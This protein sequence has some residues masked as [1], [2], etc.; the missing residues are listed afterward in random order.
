ML[1]FNQHKDLL[2]LMID[3]AEGEGGKEE[4]LTDEE[5]VV[6]CITFLLA[7][8]DTTANTLAYTSYLL[9]LNPEVQEK[10][11]A[12]IDE[13]FESNPVSWSNLHQLYVNIV[14]GTCLHWSNCS[15]IPRPLP[16]FI[17]QPEFFSTAA[18]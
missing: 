15:L 16:N 8:Y 6:H 2:Q 17:S 10:L 9:A 3:A 1:S 11:Q 13:Y 12:D 7:G 4:K 5:I 18:R 14:N